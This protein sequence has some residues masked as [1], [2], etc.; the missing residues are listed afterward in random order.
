MPRPRRDGTRPEY[1]A[2]YLCVGAVVRFI[3][4]RSRRSGHGLR[5]AGAGGVFLARRQNKMYTSVRWT[6]VPHAKFARCWQVASRMPAVR[7]LPILLLLPTTSAG[8]RHS[9][10]PGRLQEWTTASDNMLPSQLFLPLSTTSALR[11]VL[12]F[13]HGGGDGPFSVMNRQSLPHL[14]LSNRT[15]AA[16]FPF[17]GIFPCSTCGGAH[18]TFAER[19]W[20]PSNFEKVDRLLEVVIKEHG[21][22]PTRVVLTGQSMGGGGLYRYAQARRA[23][24]QF[25]ALV[26]VCAAIRPPSTA[27]GHA[28]LC[29]S[30]ATA[31]AQGCCPNIWAL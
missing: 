14:L 8:L 22:D 31:A 24:S 20:V 2:V 17:I 11:P 4:A 7:Q 21:G 15:F 27:N 26:P 12:I 13:L 10:S 28:E 16:A 3:V 6:C 18:A 25:A 23:A 19:G 9:V 29:C 5:G 30:N 1:S